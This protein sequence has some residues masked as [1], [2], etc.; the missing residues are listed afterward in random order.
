MD[1]GGGRSE[2]EWKMEN[3]KMEQNKNGKRPGQ[4]SAAGPS[5]TA[6]SMGAP[7]NQPHWVGLGVTLGVALGGIRPLDNNE[8][9][10]LSRTPRTHPTPKSFG[11]V[12]ES[13]SQFFYVF[14]F[15]LLYFFSPFFSVPLILLS[16]LSLAFFFTFFTAWWPATTF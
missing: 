8:G 11:L 9:Q 14:P 6:T 4:G 5:A 10:A 7:L 12:C 1:D 15:T 3:G 2:F 16:S 13:L